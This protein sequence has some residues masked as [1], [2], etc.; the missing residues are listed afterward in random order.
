MKSFTFVMVFA[1]VLFLNGCEKKKTEDFSIG[2]ILSETGSAAQYGKWS[3]KGIELAVSEINSR[4][5]RKLRVSFEDDATDPTTAVNAAT[6]LLNRGDIKIIIGPLTSSSVLA[7]APIMNE[8]KVVLLSPCASSP[9]IT[10]A[11]EYIFR[12]WPSDNYEGRVMA[13]YIVDSLRIKNVAV[14]SMNNEYGFG[15]REVFIARARER[16]VQIL[17]VETF[18]QDATDFRA[19]ISKILLLHVQFLYVPG[20]AKEVAR[21]IKQ[22][23]EIG[24]KTIFGSSVAF[25]SPE[26]FDVAGKAVEG[27]IF[28]APAFDLGSKNENIKKFIESYQQQYG[29]MPEVFAA[30]AYDATMIIGSAIAKDDTTSET[31]RSYLDTLKNYPG[32][33]GNTTFDLNG[34]VMKPVAIKIVKNNTFRTISVVG[35]K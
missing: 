30:H 12:N 26:I 6:R 3:R 1:T 25:G 15:V 22:S 8:K 35:D 9:K 14:L 20:H 7:V 2:A 13:D 10:N 33:T 23:T 4:A 16:G 27:T 17:F 31:I 28:T 18:E 34:D 21:I 19:Q 24:L 32:V 5:G 11:G 29:E